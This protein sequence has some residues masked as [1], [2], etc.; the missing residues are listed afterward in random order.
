M[1]IKGNDDTVFCPKMSEDRY[2]EA[3][4][5]PWSKIS[6]DLIAPVRTYDRPERVTRSKPRPRYAKKAILVVAD[7]SG[8]AAV[9]F[10]LMA[11]QSAAAFC[12]SRAR[13]FFELTRGQYW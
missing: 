8:V 2:K 4:A 10:V 5:S 13:Y 11:D 9:R 7:C 6:V 3:V 1:A 12:T